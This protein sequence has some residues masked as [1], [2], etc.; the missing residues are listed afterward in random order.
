MKNKNQEVIICQLCEKPIETPDF[1]DGILDYSQVYNYRG[2]DFHEECFDE[3]CKKVDYK[4]QEASEQMEHSLKSQQAGEWLNGG[5]KTMKT[6]IDG[7]PIVKN[8]KI[9][10]IVKDYE[11]GKL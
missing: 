5:Y 3:G 6:T 9:P 2:F 7:V 8:P 4:R 1:G 10:Q 11:D